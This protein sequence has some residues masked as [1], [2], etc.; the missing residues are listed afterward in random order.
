MSKKTSQLIIKGATVVTPEKI[1]K[2]DIKIRGGKIA[3]IKEEIRDTSSKVINAEGMLVLPGGIDMHVHFGIKMGSFF[4]TDD[5]D[6]G[7]RAAIAGGITTVADFTEP[8]EGLSAIECLEQRMGFFRSRCWCNYTFHITI[9]KKLFENTGVK[10]TM[11]EAKNF[12][13]RNYKIFTCYKKEGIGLSES[14]LAR[15]LKLAGEENALIL[16]HAEDNGSINRATQKI[17]EKHHNLASP[18]L[19]ARARPPEAEAIAIRKMIHL[20]KQ[21]SSSIHFVH[22]STGTGAETIAKA[23]LK[24]GWISC[25]T[26]PQYLILDESLYRGKNPS[27]YILSPPLRPIREKLKLWKALQN[28]FIHAIATDHCPFYKR[29]KFCHDLNKSSSYTDI[30]KGLA[31]VETL[32]PLIYTE[33][34]ESG[35]ISLKQMVK[36]ICENPAKILGLYPRKG[37]IQ[38]GSDADLVIYDPGCEWKINGEKLFA[39]S[40]YSPY[41]NMKIKGKVKYTILGGNIVLKDGKFLSSTPAG[42]F[43][44]QA[45]FSAPSL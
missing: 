30:P 6:S 41:E 42:T 12:G 39:R 22:I 23:S 3:E 15:L 25:E 26:C 35:R 2:R 19:H 43:I 32:L 45:P 17:E 16:V 13:I 4:S 9:S 34:V 37:T 36:L 20:Q 40:D 8:I 11:R 29:Q 31:G 5:P 38:K 44:P 18:I 27:L 14:Q 10:K 24:H 7:S 33:G 21:T 1:A 28:G